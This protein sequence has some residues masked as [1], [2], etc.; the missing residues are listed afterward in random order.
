MP[1]PQPLLHQPNANIHHPSLILQYHLIS[2]LASAVVHPPMILRCQLCQQV[3]I[4]LIQLLLMNK[5]TSPSHNLSS[6]SHILYLSSLT[7]SLIILLC[8]SWTAHPESHWPSPM[9]PPAHFI[10]MPPSNPTPTKLLAHQSPLSLPKV[11][12]IGCESLWLRSWKSLLVLTSPEP[13]IF[14]ANS[15][16]N[17]ISPTKHKATWKTVAPNFSMMG[18]RW[19]QLL[20]LS[21]CHQCYFIHYYLVDLVVHS[22]AIM[23]QISLSIDKDWRSV[24]LGATHCPWCKWNAGGHCLSL[25]VGEVSAEKG[26][27]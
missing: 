20:N 27:G 23:A 26:W 25:L 16:A 15:S 18:H 14:S 2:L 11:L 12:Q 8:P 4:L 6:R 5:A 22:T 10:M 21:H 13:S 19:S 9:I 24:K 17:K 7:A 3:R 1:I